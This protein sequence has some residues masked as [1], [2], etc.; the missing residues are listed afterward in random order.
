[1][2]EPIC[3]A[4]SGVHPEQLSRVQS[5]AK[6]VFTEAK[7]IRDEEIL[8]PSEWRQRARLLKDKLGLDLSGN[9]VTHR[10]LNGMDTTEMPTYRTFVNTYRLVKSRRIQDHQL[11]EWLRLTLKEE[12]KNKFRDMSQQLFLGA[13]LFFYKYIPQQGVA[14]CYM[15]KN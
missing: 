2:S 12:D 8:S 14:W 7:A 4:Q 9:E 10:I 6:R 1:M 11:L 13:Q 15:A 5:E 3:H